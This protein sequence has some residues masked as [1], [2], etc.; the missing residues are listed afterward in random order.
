MEKDYKRNGEVLSGMAVPEG[1]HRVV[2]GV[3][4]LGAAYHG[5]QKQAS[6][7]NTVQAHLE[8]ALS[9]IASEQVTLVCAGRTDAGV[10]AT[11]QVV[12]F[13]TLAD[14]PIKA[15]VQGS[16]AHLPDEIRVT[17]AQVAGFDFHAR[18]SA[19]SRTYQYRI[20]CAPVHSAMLGRLVT[21]TSQPLDVSLMAAG[22][23]Y[24]LGEHDFSAFRAAQC[25][26]HSPV[27]E[28]QRLTLTESGAFI[29]LEVRANAF[30]HHMVR[31]LVGS[32]LVVGR[33]GQAPVWMGEL[34]AG[35][36]RRL[37][38]PTAP[39]WGLSLVAVE[40]PD[41]FAIPDMRHRSFFMQ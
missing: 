27:R 7:P 38:A 1:M 30:L 2:L 16:N 11:G 20:Y 40:Y 14:R 23:N 18:F 26:A 17:W 4:Y 34:L 33:G 19:L 24:L 22:A 31:N 37:A 5:F 35:K 39:P 15:W 6:T 8:N 9:K 3:E 10:S 21:W 36:D 29:V 32:L 41:R 13:D 25:Q 12:H 28:I